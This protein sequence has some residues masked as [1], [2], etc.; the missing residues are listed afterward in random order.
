[1]TKLTPLGKT[2]KVEVIACNTPTGCAHKHLVGQH[3]IVI[4]I[5]DDHAM[6]QFSGGYMKWLPFYH[7]E[8]IG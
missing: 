1:M 7:I 4:R 3:G 8:Q 5:E 2:S 6:I